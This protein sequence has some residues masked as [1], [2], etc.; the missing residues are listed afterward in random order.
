MCSTA[1]IRNNVP[2]CLPATIRQSMCTIR[3]NIDY[4]N[5]NKG[6]VIYVFQARLDKESKWVLSTMCVRFVRYSA[7]SPFQLEYPICYFFFSKVFSIWKN[8][9]G[10]EWRNSINS[11]NT[12]APFSDP[13]IRCSIA[14]IGLQKKKRLPSPNKHTRI[15]HLN[16]KKL[17]R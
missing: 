6:W 3:A 8:S 13:F 12:R 1:C 4:R 16:L 7:S 9:H 17:C 2:Y 14:W 5:R 10:G 15:R 11:N